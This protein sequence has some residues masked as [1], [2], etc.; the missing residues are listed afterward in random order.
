MIQPLQ[1]K[2]FKD[3]NGLPYTKPPTTDDIMQKLNEV[4]WAVNALVEKPKKA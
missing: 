2:A 4:I 3:D 1:G